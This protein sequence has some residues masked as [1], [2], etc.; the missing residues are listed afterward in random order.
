[1]EK[2]ILLALL[3]STALSI[4]AQRTISSSGGNALGTGGT[5]SF[6]VG[7][8]VYTSNT[9]SLG[10]VSQGVQQ[11]FEI[12][13]LSNPD[14]LTVQLKAVFCP[15]PTKDYFVLKITDTALENLQYTLFDLNGKTIDSKKI[16]TSSTEITMKNYSIGMYLL[17]LTKKN[18]SIKTFKII[19]NK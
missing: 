6:T 17:K 3:L 12:Q 18:Q 14:L 13:T 9:S 4:H 5:S 2:N 7:Q 19:K 15:N 8:V 11:A 1:M 10:S 16:R